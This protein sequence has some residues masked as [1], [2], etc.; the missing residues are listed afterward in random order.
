MEKIDVN[1]A[2]LKKADVDA[3]I[4]VR[5]VGGFF[6]SKGQRLRMMLRVVEECEVRVTYLSAEQE[7]VIVLENPRKSSEYSSSEMRLS[8]QSFYW[9]GFGHIWKTPSEHHPHILFD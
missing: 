5:S 3:V 6:D 4:R 7:V 8:Y 2:W 1:L 9:E